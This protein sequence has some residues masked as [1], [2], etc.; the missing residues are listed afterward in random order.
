MCRCNFGAVHAPATDLHQA[1]S[2]HQEL[3]LWAAW[4]P[5]HTPAAHGGQPTQA[6][7]QGPPAA[8]CVAPAP[9]APSTHLD[10]AADAVLDTALQRLAGNGTV[11]CMAQVLPCRSG[12]A[13]QRCELQ[14]RW[15]LQQPRRW[16]GKTTRRSKQQPSCGWRKPQYPNG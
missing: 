13:V 15:A 8:I 16:L 10:V 7:Q 5:C 4:G 12:G 3:H 11:Q 2:S 1:D 9:P 6:S 14:K